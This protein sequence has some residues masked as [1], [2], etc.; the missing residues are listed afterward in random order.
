MITTISAAS[1]ATSWCT[2]TRSRSTGCWAGALESRGSKSPTSRSWSTASAPSA[3][4]PARLRER[5]APLLNGPAGLGAPGSG[6][7]G[8]LGR[9]RLAG[10]AKAVDVQTVAQYVQAALVGGLRQRRFETH[11]EVFGEGETFH[12]AAVLSTQVMGMPGQVLGRPVA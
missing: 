12:Q 1:T 3:P 9:R 6:R 8:S 2:S 7:P 10:L 11:L 5:P 4:R